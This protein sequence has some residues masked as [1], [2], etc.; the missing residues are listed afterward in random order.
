[1]PTYPCL[2]VVS[3]ASSTVPNA[4]HRYKYAYNQKNRYK[5]KEK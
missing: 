5:D 1:M 3:F 2:L 4:K